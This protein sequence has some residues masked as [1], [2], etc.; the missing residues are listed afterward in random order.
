M[1]II[2]W[3]L[4]EG[5]RE[6]CRKSG[7]LRLLVVE[8]GVDAPICADIREDWIRAPST[9]EDVQARIAMLQA[10]NLGYCL[11]QV[12]P[13]GIV[14]CG[15]RSVAVSPTE[16]ELVRLLTVHFGEMVPRESLRKR[17]CGGNRRVSRNALDLHI[18]RIRRR[19]AP[20]RLEIRTAWG[21]GY[22]LTTGESEGIEPVLPDS[23]RRNRG[24]LPGI[25]RSDARAPGRPC[26]ESSR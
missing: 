9:R 7:E 2:R 5:K 6:R 1:K 10:R 19:I 20:L 16:A 18:M 12:D 25:P 21:R 24:A 11:P 26:E 8:G 17:L 14:R 22:T 3:P 15:P 13:A 4:E 23:G